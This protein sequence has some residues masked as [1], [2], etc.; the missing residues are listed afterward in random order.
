MNAAVVKIGGS[1]VAYPEK[2]KTLCA[3]LGRTL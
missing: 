1:L 3:M 2:L